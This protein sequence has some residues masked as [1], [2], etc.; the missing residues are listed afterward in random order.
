M[1]WNT[2]RNSS[3]P[4]PPDRLIHR[5][6]RLAIGV[7]GVDLSHRL[8]E[9][10]VESLNILSGV[11]VLS[12]AESCSAGSSSTSRSPGNGSAGIGS[13]GSVPPAS[14]LPPAL[15]RRLSLGIR[16]GCFVA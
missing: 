10:G 12:S 3:R 14:V 1:S 2:S 11:G 6:Q 16:H 7:E 5:L 4:L 8:V 13:A 9:V 15:R